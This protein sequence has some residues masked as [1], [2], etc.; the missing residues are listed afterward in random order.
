MSTGKL[1]KAQYELLENFGLR[2]IDDS[3]IKIEEL[4]KAVHQAILLFPFK[5]VSDMEYMQVVGEIAEG[6]YYEDD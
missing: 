2:R 1:T 3:M 4:R 6:R 5:S